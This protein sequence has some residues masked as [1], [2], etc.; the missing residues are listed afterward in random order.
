MPEPARLPSAQV[1]VPRIVR[2]VGQLP[3]RGSHLP[4]GILLALCW[5]AWLWFVVE[6]RSMAKWGISAASLAEG[7]YDTLLLTMFAH[8]GLLH[9]GMN[10]AVLA[11]LAPVTVGAMGG[12]RRGAGPFFA[13]Y[14]LAGLAGSLL[15]VAFNPDG[16]I[17]AVG[18][19]GAI[20]G[21][22][23]FVARLGTHGRL[24]PLLGR[25][26]ALRIWDFLKAN[27]ILIA[28]FALPALFGGGGIMIAWEA[29]LG[30]FLFGLLTAGWFLRHRAPA[31]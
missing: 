27:L 16:T 3:S 21:L 4:G 18:A 30:G 5:G 14:L 24:L 1:S 26:L 8:A 28:L 20:S 17:P 23:G 19:S 31:S 7:R 15:Y 6:G 29:H 25:E 10:S 22:I 12:A 13:F 2:S 9:L 11:S